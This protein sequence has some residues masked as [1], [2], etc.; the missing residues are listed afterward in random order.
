MRED[1]KIA[2][3]YES[4]R[5]MSRLTWIRMYLEFGYN[6]YI[7][8]RTQIFE[9]I[10]EHNYNGFLSRYKELKKAGALKTSMFGLKSKRGIQGIKFQL[11]PPSYWTGKGIKK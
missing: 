6:P 10:G 3:S 4:I 8:T 1:I 9:A 2:A 11:V 5:H 7:T